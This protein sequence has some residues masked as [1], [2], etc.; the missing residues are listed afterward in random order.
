LLL[1]T[2]RGSSSQWHTETRTAKSAVLRKL[3][4]R[5]PYIEIDPD[6]AQALGIGPTD[7]VRVTSQR[8]SIEARAHITRVVARGQCFMPMHFPDTNV[9]TL[10]SFDPHSRQPAYKGCAVKIEKLKDRTAVLG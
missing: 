9:L 2:G 6:D 10:A 5:V 8:G 1:L 7:W 4:P 3:A